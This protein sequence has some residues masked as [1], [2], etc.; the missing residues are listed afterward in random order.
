MLDRLP[1]DCFQLILNNLKEIDRLQTTYLCKSLYSLKLDILVPQFELY[2]LDK[3]RDMSIKYI[4]KYI[5]RGY[6]LSLVA[7]S[8]PVN[9]NTYNLDKFYILDLSHTKVTD[10]SMLGRV[11]TLDLS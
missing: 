4:K 11:H 2:K 5:N 6:K 9:I 3:R 10:V 7:T 1:F 8:N